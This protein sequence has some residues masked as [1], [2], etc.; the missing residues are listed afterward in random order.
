MKHVLTIPPVILLTILGACG[1]DDTTAVNR[2]TLAAGRPE[3]AIVVDSLIPA[4]I[5]AFGI[6]APIQQAT[7]S[8]RLMGAVTA[9]LVHEGD[10][11]RAGQLLL[12][13]DTRELAAKSQQANAG[14]GAAQAQATEAERYAERIRALYAD[15]AAPK[16]MLDAAE[17][18]ALRAQ[19]GLT[20]AQ[21]MQQEL[22]AV[23]DYGE[24]RAPFAGV[25]TRRWVDAGAFAAPGAPLV[26]LED[27][28]ALRISVSTTPSLAT[29][30]HRGATIEARIE[31]R[32]TLAVI[33]G[34]VP[35]QGGGLYT[36]NAVVRDPAGQFSSG[37]AASLLVP[38]GTRHAIL[39][40]VGAI[41]RQGDLTGVRIWQGERADLRW[42]RLGVA[43]GQW[44][45]VLSGLGAGD[46]VVVLPATEGN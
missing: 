8:T 25:V 9:V 16:A 18:G 40:P 12:R 10:R 5:E 6:A 17:T 34:V 30:L 43:R 26:T 41:V 29:Q 14:L 2:A 19:A 36:I 32:P 45:E 7:V 28:S 38:Q 44:I 39:A 24:L 33:E 4:G 35:V 46:S 15:S 22:A 37:G 3:L 20:Q 23:A 13:I 21:A 11:V 42:V 31:G 27:H 1:R